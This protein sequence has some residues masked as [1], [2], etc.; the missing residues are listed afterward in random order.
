MI[1]CSH[2]SQIF[3]TYQI[4]DAFLL[5]AFSSSETLL[6]YLSSS[7]SKMLPNTE[8]KLWQNPLNIPTLV[9]LF[10]IHSLSRKS[11]LNSFACEN[12]TWESHTWISLLTYYYLLKMLYPTSVE[13]VWS[14]VSIFYI[15]MPLQLRQER[16]LHPHLYPPWLLA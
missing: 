14:F 11:S 5:F 6:N 3:N 8:T 9:L 13:Y 15:L 12:S 2:T 1:I 4:K 16:L 7:I 10:T